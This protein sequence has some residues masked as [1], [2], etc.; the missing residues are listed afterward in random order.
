VD[1]FGPGI[2]GDKPAVT[3]GEVVTYI[4]LA[5]PWESLRRAVKD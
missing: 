1:R 3:A 4:F 2:V 5:V